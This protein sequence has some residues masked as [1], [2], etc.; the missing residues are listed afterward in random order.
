[1]SGTGKGSKGGK[2][3]KVSGTDL[4]FFLHAAGFRRLVPQVLPQRVVDGRFV[5]E[6]RRHIVGQP[7]DS[8]TLMIAC[9][10]LTAHTP[11]IE[12]KSYSGRSSSS[13]GSVGSGKVAIFMKTIFV[14]P[15]TTVNE[16]LSRVVTPTPRDR[17]GKS[18]ETE[19]P[20]PGSMVV[21][22]RP[23]GELQF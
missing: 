19:L 17:L 14:R 3:A 1:M 23:V 16:A 18:R 4:P 6:C 21:V 11:R 10:V 5:G 7:D 12:R 20:R 2:G 8:Q 13:T 15:R 22:A 9:R